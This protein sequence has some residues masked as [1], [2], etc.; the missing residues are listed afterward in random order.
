VRLGVVVATWGVR[1]W[2][3]ARFGQTQDPN[4]IGYSSLGEVKRPP[5][6]LMGGF[7]QTL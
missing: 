4:H 6:L 2:I 7:E 1:G 5:V 3:W